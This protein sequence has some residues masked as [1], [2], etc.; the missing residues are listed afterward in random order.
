MNHELPMAGHLLVAFALTYAL[1]FER[2]LRGAAAGDRTFSLIGVGAAVVAALAQHGAPNVL[3][4]VITGVGFIGGGL[5]FRET[6]ATGDVVRGITTAAT[7]FAAAAVGAAA[8]Q[9]LLLL[10]AIGTGL[11]LLTLEIRHIPGLRLLDGRRWARDFAED[12]HCEGEPTPSAPGSPTRLDP[13]DE[14][15]LDAARSSEEADR[16]RV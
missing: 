14:D 3:T 10:A 4:G 16:S 13:A 12:D 11:A 1:G 7:I 8:G 9:G 15:L 5:V 2:S 6:R